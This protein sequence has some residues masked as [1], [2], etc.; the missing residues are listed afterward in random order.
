VKFKA[1]TGR[2]PP[3]PGGTGTALGEGTAGQQRRS[4][5]IAAGRPQPES[6]SNT[7]VLALGR[8]VGL[9]LRAPPPAAAEGEAVW[10]VAMVG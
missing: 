8:I 3:A 2:H 4:K 5:R 10:E 6:L 1:R 9:A 7:A